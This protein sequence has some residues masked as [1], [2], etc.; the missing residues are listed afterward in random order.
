[1]SQMAFVS[2]QDFIEKQ[3]RFGRFSDRAGG[4][5]NVGHCWRCGRRRNL[6]NMPYN[7]M[8]ADPV[9]SDAVGL[10]HDVAAHK[11]VAGAV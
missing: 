6:T 2:Q 7:D 5:L 8:D 11:L 10:R 9:R 4:G 3:T 1:M